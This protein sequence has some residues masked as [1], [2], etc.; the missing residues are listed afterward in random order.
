MRGKESDNSE[1][2]IKYLARYSCFD[3]VNLATYKYFD[4]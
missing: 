1:I 4:G 3:W 2:E